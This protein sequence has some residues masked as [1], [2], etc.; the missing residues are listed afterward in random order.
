MWDDEIRFVVRNAL[1]QR[2]V[3]LFCGKKSIHLAAATPDVEIYT[4]VELTARQ[5]LHLAASISLAWA[6]LVGAGVATWTVRVEYPR[7]RDQAAEFNRSAGC[8]LEKGDFGRA[9][10]Q[11]LNAIQRQPRNLTAQWGLAQCALQLKRLPEARKA[12]EQVVSM[13]GSNRMA[14]AALVDLLLKQGKAKRALEHAMRAVEENPS[15][16]AEMVRLGKCQLLL[17]RLRAARRLAEDAI[18]SSPSNVEARLLAAATAA[19]DGD[20]SAARKHVFLA[21]QSAPEAELDRLVAARILGKCGDYA[22][23]Q[24]QL[25]K[26]LAKDSANWIA[27]QER[28]E[29]R[30]AAGDMN[31]AIQEYRKLSMRPGVDGKVQIRLAELLL[32]SKRLDEAHAAGETLLRLMPQNKAGHMVLAIIYYEKKL[33]SASAEHCRASLA[34]EPRSISVRLLMTKVLMAQGRFAEAATWLAELNEEGRTSPEILLL[35][36]ECH[37]ALGSRK[38]AR[39]TLDAAMVLQPQSP[40]PYLLL[41]RFHLANDEYRQAI[42]ACRRAHEL[43][44]Q[45]VMALNNLAALLSARKAGD[46]RDLAKAFELASAAWNLQPGNPDIAETLGWIYAQRGEHAAGF[47]LL[48]YS[49]RQHPSNAVARLHVAHVLAEMKRYGEAADQ[50]SYAQELLPALAGEEEYQTLLKS[51]P[52]PDA[53]AEVAL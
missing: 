24:A 37:V 47:H 12:L 48:A 29:L 14:R 21:V 32:A 42:A 27:A 31:G 11:Y 34:I 45:N 43:D 7:S 51:L 2:M 5:L 25:E 1:T 41:A 9:R 23:A 49:V 35:L 13:D 30:L 6:L 8:L 53:A 46:H 33:W 17:G 38:D 40:V 18:C 10:I 3:G 28:A 36:A 4:R 15:G 39:E 44:P 19:E 50:L 52:A 22:A 16:I 20:Y 26:L